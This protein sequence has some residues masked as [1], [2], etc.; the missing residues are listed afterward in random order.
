MAEAIEYT[1]TYTYVRTVYMVYIRYNN[2]VW[3][4]G[5]LTRWHCVL[6]GM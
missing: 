5:V 3:A 1:Y 4:A 2:L 6:D